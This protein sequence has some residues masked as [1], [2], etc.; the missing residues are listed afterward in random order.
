MQ[1]LAQPGLVTWLLERHRG[2]RAGEASPSGV[3]VQGK[4]QPG[5]TAR[6]EYC[7]LRIH[8]PR[9]NCWDSDGR[10][11]SDWQ[12]HSHDEETADPPRDPDCL[13]AAAPGDHELLLA[14]PDDLRRGAGDRRRQLH[15]LGIVDGIRALRRSRR[16]RLGWACFFARGRTPSLLFTSLGRLPVSLAVA[17]VI[18]WMRVKKAPLWRSSDDRGGACC[19]VGERGNSVR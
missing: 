11:R 13:D 5:V 19:L 4:I 9:T 1:G 14:V 17:P 15:R 6:R 10:Q 12:T 7:I 8:I 3:E 16:L 18:Y 2:D